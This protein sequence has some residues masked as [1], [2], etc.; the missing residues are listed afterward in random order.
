M[1]RLTSLASHLETNCESWEGNAMG[2]LD[3][4]A[5]PEGPRAESN[6]KKFVRVTGTRLDRYVEFEFSVNDAD[7]MVELILPFEAFHEFCV[8]QHATV[9]PPE[10]VA[11]NQLEQLAWRS[12]QPGLLRRIKNA[13]EG[14]TEATDD[15]TRTVEPKSFLGGK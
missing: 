15:D 14:E 4:G 5:G 10:S 1:S 7:L 3:A 2:Q 12:R 11:A 9:L 13:A 6:I 8:L